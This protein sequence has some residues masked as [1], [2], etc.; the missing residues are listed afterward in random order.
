MDDEFGPAYSR[1]LADR[2]VLGALSGR[3]P[4]EAI[5]AGVPPK[6]V[7]AALCDAMDV[8]ADRRLGRER[9]PAPPGRD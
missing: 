4:A 6:Q 2:Q 9:P 1:V 5:E 8:P 3:T 7:W